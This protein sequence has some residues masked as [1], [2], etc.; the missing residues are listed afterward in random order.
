MY[1]C[2][3]ALFV[4]FVNV[5]CCDWYGYLAEGG[6]SLVPLDGGRYKVIKEKVFLSHF[7]S[8]IVDLSSK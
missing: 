1:R 8:P 3:D 4:S 5:C 6:G 2:L 7:W